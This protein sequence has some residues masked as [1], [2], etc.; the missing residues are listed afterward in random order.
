MLREAVETVLSSFAKHTGQVGEG[1]F[2]MNG[3]DIS[4]TH[5]CRKH[6]EDEEAGLNMSYPIVDSYLKFTCLSAKCQKTN[7]VKYS[8]QK[9]W[10]N[11]A[12]AI[13]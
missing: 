1:K 7:A 13:L 12:N 2:I 9:Y 10:L 5:Q 3:D 4:Q 8:I 11:K 6:L